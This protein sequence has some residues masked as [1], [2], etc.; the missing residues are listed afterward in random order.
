[1]VEAARQLNVKF[2]HFRNSDTGILDLVFDSYLERNARSPVDFLTWVDES[3]N[4]SEL[5]REFQAG[6]LSNILVNKILRRE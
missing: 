3:Y 1:M 5:E 4:P 2:G 6:S